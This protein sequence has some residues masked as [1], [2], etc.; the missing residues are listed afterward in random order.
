MDDR[1]VTRANGPDLAIWHLVLMPDAEVTD[2][3]GP[4]T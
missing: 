3:I 1:D 4:L 2:Y